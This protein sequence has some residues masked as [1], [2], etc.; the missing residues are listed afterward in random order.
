[1][2]QILSSWKE[3]ASFFGKGIRT[4]QRW[5]QNLGLP[6]HRP[7]GASK[8]IVLA[9]IDE[10]SEWLNAKQ[11]QVLKCVLLAEADPNQEALIESFLTLSGY[12][13]ISYPEA[14]DPGEQLNVIE[15]IDLLLIDLQL[16]DGMEIVKNLRKKK[17]N[18]PAI[19]MSSDASCIERLRE[20][21]L[22]TCQILRKPFRFPELQLLMESC[23]HE[24]PQPQKRKVVSFPSGAAEADKHY[25]VQAS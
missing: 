2:N 10:L 20:G 1:M 14:L 15:G 9:N 17:D 21:P 13:V 12:E 8:N 7:Q 18:L 5:E 22:Q 19:L 4:V 16:R 3:I 6:V 23:L 11:Q 24:V 25:S